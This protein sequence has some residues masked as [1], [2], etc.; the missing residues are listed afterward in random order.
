M[1][2]WV[3]ILGCDP[4]LRLWAFV[5]SPGRSLPHCSE[6]MALSTSSVYGRHL[7]ASAGPG[8]PSMRMLRRPLFF[9][10]LSFH[11]VL[12]ILPRTPNLFLCQC[13]LSLQSSHQPLLRPPRRKSTTHTTL[14]MTRTSNRHI[15]S[16][17]TQPPRAS[18]LSKPQPRKTAVRPI[19]SRRVST[20]LSGRIPI[21]K[22]SMIGPGPVGKFSTLAL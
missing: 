19:D 11:F 1:T 3:L 22:L 7:H 16:L 9:R 14:I 20:T 5:S 8:T 4:R 17:P 18:Q 10:F 12:S 6:V 21:H 2:R 13:S 15:S